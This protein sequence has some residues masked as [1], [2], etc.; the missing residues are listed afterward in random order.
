MSIS[1][2]F[3]I[4]MT[5]L[6]LASRA[7][8]TVSSNLANANTDGYGVRRVVQ[9]TQT[10]GGAGA[11]VRL[12][13]IERQVDSGL[14]GERRLAEGGQG[15]Q[16]ATST[17]LDRIENI[18]G[19]PGEP[20]SLADRVGRL[21]AALADAAATPQSDITLAA[22]A[23]ALKDLALGLGQASEGVQSLR[24]EA[25]A[26]IASQVNT[27][28]A[29][30]SELQTLNADMIRL[31]G[32]G[33]DTS[34]LED[35]RQVLVDTVSRIVPVREVP[36]SNG[37]IA[38]ITPGGATLLD[39]PPAQIEFT[40]TTYITA[41][42]SYPAGTL[43]GLILN[44]APLDM[45]SNG[46]GR[47]GGGTLAAAF[48]TRDEIAQDAQADLD[49]FALDLVTRFQGPSVDP[50]Q[51]VTDPGLFTDSGAAFSAPDAVG[52]SGRI[53]VNPAVLPDQGGALWRLRDGLG[54]AAAGP[55]GNGAQLNA[56]RD[57]LT[58]ARAQPDTSLATAA[59]LAG[60][61]SGRIGGARTAAAGNLAYASARFDSLREAELRGGVDSDAELQRLMVIE[62]AFAANARVIETAEAM[63]RQIMEL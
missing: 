35:R 21:E 39:G 19:L 44:G 27:L 31:A 51:G 17:A 38:L 58:T 43:N 54:A 59:D 15:F 42:L 23:T 29:S 46:G 2:T 26:D 12:I 11:G 9:G 52:L 14:L 62:Q 25:D 50:T 60:R 16:N 37:Q 36:R 4:A 1:S 63:M 24:R 56:W 34:A 10:I 57:A 61:I 28:N 45:S 48:A 49:A 32:A 41:E 5:G 18:I 30:L 33:R 40:P 47:L 53:A 20:G 13:G 55:V 6:T 7:A 8:Q 3:T 22:A